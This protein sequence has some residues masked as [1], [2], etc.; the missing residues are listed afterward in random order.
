[1]NWCLPG[2]SEGDQ[3]HPDVAPLRLQPGANR[4]FDGQPLHVW[5]KDKGVFVS[6]SEW[7]VQVQC[8][9]AENWDQGVALGEKGMKRCR[10]DHRARC[11]YI[12]FS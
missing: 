9:R 11:E 5:V 7:A 3:I 8:G 4:P 1:M 12:E 10:K 2:V 6:A